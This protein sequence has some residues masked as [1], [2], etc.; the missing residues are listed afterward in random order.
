MMVY[1]A[2]APCGCVHG[3]DFEGGPETRAQI[4]EWVR[5]GSRVELRSD[6]DGIRC[7]CPHDPKWGRPS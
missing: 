4:A 5:R 2:I 6:A 1:V 7:D 3:A